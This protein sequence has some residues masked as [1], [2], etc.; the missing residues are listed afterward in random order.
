V[1]RV[2]GLPLVFPL[3]GAPALQR[4]QHVRLRI[5]HCDDLSLDVTAEF[6]AM[7]SEMPGPEADADAD[8]DDDHLPTAG[9]GLALDLQEESP[10]AA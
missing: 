8:A 5:T 1:V 2:V 9:L 6:L 10:P 3:L 7:A 4:G